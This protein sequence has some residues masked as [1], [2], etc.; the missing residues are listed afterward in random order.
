MGKVGRVGLEGAVR[1]PEDPAALGGLEVVPGGS[2]VRGVGFPIFSAFLIRISR[3]RIITML[4]IPDDR[5]ENSRRVH[6]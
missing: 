6:Y 3:P 5:D 2:K 1:G 4:L